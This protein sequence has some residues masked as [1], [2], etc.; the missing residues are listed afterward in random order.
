MTSHY[1]AVYRAVSDIPG[2]ATLVRTH[3]SFEEPRYLYDNPEA[4]FR[5]LE[6][7]V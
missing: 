6:I 1:D 2:K 3:E 7:A 5:D 4:T